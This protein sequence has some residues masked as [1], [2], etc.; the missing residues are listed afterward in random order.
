MAQ[1]TGNGA[2]FTQFHGNGAHFKK[3]KTKCSRE[4]K[5]GY[6]K[7]IYMKRAILFKIYNI[8]AHTWS[9]S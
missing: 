1:I 8:M 2:L 5:N 9:K 7:R 4:M 3:F 6:F